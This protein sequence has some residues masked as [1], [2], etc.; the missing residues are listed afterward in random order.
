MKEGSR[1][2]NKMVLICMNG[3]WTFES[4]KKCKSK[5]G[6]LLFGS[7]YVLQDI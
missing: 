4:H 3:Q 1:L 2:K 5:D 6:S 7:A